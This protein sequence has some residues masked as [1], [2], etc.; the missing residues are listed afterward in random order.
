MREVEVGL[1]VGKVVEAFEFVSDDFDL[2]TALVPGIEYA[3]CTPFPDSVVEIASSTGWR[4]RVPLIAV[5]VGVGVGVGVE[6]GVGVG[7]VG[8]VRVVGWRVANEL[9][10]EELLVGSVLSKVVDMLFDVFCEL[11]V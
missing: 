1:R 10:D 8:G 4:V 3:T 11:L 9:L 6:V 7:W 5:G 2:E